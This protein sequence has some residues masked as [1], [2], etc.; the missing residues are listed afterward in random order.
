MR[1]C[2]AHTPR[3]AWNLAPPPLSVRAEANMA[4]ISVGGG[5]GGKK[6]VDADIPLIPFIDLLLCCVMFLLVT[7]VWNRLASVEVNQDL[8]SAQAPDIARPETLS[9]FLHVTH[10]GYVL[11]TNAGDR[12]EIARNGDAYDSET[13]RTRLSERHAADP[14]RHDI[15]VAPEDGVQY[16][17]VIASMDAAIGAGFD[18]VRLTDGAHL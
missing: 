9:L 2:R 14:N 6:A 18:D 10:D 5:H 15:I 7:A 17:D 13:L 8:P 4:S 3:V 1:S 16:A 11:S 12:V